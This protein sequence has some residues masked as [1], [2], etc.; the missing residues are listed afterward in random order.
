MGI[1]SYFRRILTTYPRLVKRVEDMNTNDESGEIGALCMDFNCLIYTVART[2]TKEIMAYPGPGEEGDAWERALC[3]EIAKTTHKIWVLS[4]KPYWCVLC[5]D[6]V[7]P[8]AKIRQQ[9]MRRFKS[10]WLKKI[11]GSG[12][13][14]SGDWDTNCITP[15]TA[16]MKRLA[17][18]LRLLEGSCGGRGG[19]VLSATDEP[20]EGEHKIMRWISAHA[21]ELN[22]AEREAGVFVYGLDADLILLTMLASRALTVPLYLLREHTEFG[23]VVA[24]TSGSAGGGAS[25]MSY[26]CLPV[27]ELKEIIGLRS[28]AEIVNYVALMSFMG[29][30]FL[31]H[32][33]THR[34][35][36]DGHDLV[37]RELRRGGGN[38]LLEKRGDRWMYRKEAVLEIWSR[39][40]VDEDRRLSKMIER[41]RAVA[42]LPPRVGADG[43]PQPEYESWP[44][45]WDVEKA[46]VEKGDGGARLARGWKD[47]YW[48]FLHPYADAEYKKQV[49]EEYWR[50]MQWILDY[51]TGHQDVSLD[52]VFPAWIPPL[53]SDLRDWLSRG[54]EGG[55][56]RELEEYSDSGTGSGEPIL[57]EEQLAMVLPMESYWL[58][59]NR[60]LRRLPIVAPQWFPGKFEIHSVG[61]RW[62]W[63]CEVLVPTVTKSALREAV[64]SLELS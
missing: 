27:H 42:K 64:A 16:F 60:T 28:D 33:L 37:L 3:K 15:G 8:M 53:F 35:T 23:G 21:A 51:Y 36:E 30:D 19:F 13:S 24:G 45:Q 40:S 26:V 57:P 59:E 22:A 34:L 2:F 58:L 29:N 14:E 56:Q 10:A 20:G 38:S 9:R 43:N 17:A 5:L 6:G 47:A 25:E 63:E 52:W 18:E 31:P 54:G 7:V 61:K 50:G 62:M 46:F 55:M 49:C 48:G 12:V 44:L 39:W 1:P 4:G 41:K 11:G 32:G